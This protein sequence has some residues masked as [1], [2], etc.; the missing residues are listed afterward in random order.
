MIHDDEIKIVRNVLILI[1]F[2][3]VTIMFFRSLFS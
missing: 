2:V 3:I 1:A